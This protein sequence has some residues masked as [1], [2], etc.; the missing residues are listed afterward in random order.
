VLQTAFDSNIA[1]TALWDGGAVLRIAGIAH[2]AFN[3]C[4]LVNSTETAPQDNVNPAKSGRVGGAVNVDEFARL[5]MQL[6]VL[7]DNIAEYGGSVRSSGSTEVRSS[8]QLQWSFHGALE[9]LTKCSSTD[10]RIRAYLKQD[11]HASCEA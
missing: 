4:S 10:I 1:H 11:Y 2:A 5:S 7:R 6:C 3:A 8:L 9:E